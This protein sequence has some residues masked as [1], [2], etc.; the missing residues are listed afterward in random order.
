MARTIEKA[1][2][3]SRRGNTTT[4]T[5]GPTYSVDYRDKVILINDD[6][7]GEEATVLLPAVLNCEN[8]E[9]TIKKIGTTAAVIVDGNS[10]E[11]IDG[12]ATQTISMQYDAMHIICDGTEWWII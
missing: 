11:T 8:R 3:P 1:G 9:L 12:A 4:V 7:I 10:A 5:S 2:Q 6:S